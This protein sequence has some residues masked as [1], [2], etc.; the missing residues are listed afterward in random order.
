MKTY[1][2]FIFLVLFGSCNFALADTAPLQIT[3]VMYD[4]PGTDENH[5]YIKIENIG[6]DPVDDDPIPED[7]EPEVESMPINLLINEIMYDISG[8]DDGREWIEVYNAGLG[9]V[10]LSALKLFENETN[11][12]ITAVASAIV[13]AGGFAVIAL[14]PEKFSVD[15]PE[16]PGLVFDS[17][18]SLSNTGEDLAL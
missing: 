11:H 10:D 5:E 14:D 8:T 18:F 7:D 12:G 9:D 15:W 2:Y 3:E 16:F 4:F 17:T 6:A 13:P 1:F